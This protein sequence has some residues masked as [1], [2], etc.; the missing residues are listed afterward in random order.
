[1]QARNCAKSQEEINHE[2]S[3]SICQKINLFADFS[4]TQH[5]RTVA[6]SDAFPLP[7]LSGFAHMYAK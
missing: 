5:R 3:K 1:M 4:I 2:K 6:A 7:V